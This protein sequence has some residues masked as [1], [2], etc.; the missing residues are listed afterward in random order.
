MDEFLPRPGM[1]GGAVWAHDWHP[2]SDYQTVH[3]S[4]LRKLED[5]GIL[6]DERLSTVERTQGKR[7]LAVRIIGELRCRRD[8]AISVDKVLEVRYA[9]DV[10]EVR[11]TRYDY[12]AWLTSTEQS[13][14]RYDMSHYW[15]S[16][17]CHLFDLTSGEE[18][19][20][21]NVL[22]EHLPSLDEFVRI[23]DRRVQDAHAG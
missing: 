12:H 13:I 17:H 9:S 6:L 4:H 14:I 16:L 1:A 23:A 5:D 19:I 21:T 18:T 7:L 22:V 11:G 2:Y 20:H 8:V 10:P 3:Y 15:L